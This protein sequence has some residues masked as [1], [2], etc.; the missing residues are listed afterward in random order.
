MI[1]AVILQI[2]LIALNA[3]FA[4]AEIAVISMGDTKLQMMAEEGNKKAVTL[5][6]LTKNP[7]KFLATIQVAITLSGFLG[8][9]YAAD[10][11]AEPLVE[12][13]VRFGI[14]IP[15]PVLDAV[16]VFAITLVISYFS[17]VFGELIPKR[18]AMQKK[19]GI[20]FALAGMLFVVSKIFAPLVWLLTASTNGVLKLLHIDPEQ[21]ERVTEE[22][23]RMMVEA[24]SEKGTIDMDENEMIQNVFE[25]NDI[26]AGAIC[27]HRKDVLV[28]EQEE[29]IEEWDEIIVGSRHRFYPVSGE[30]VDDII[31]VLD[32]KDYLR[33]KMHTKEEA[34]EKAIEEPF[35]VP[36]T[37]KADVLLQDMRKLGTYVAIVIDEYGGMEGIVTVKDLLEILVGDMRDN[38]GDG[39]VDIEKI[40]ENTWR[41]RGGALLKD[42]ADELEVELPE[43]DYDTFNGYICDLLGKVPVDG[44]HFSLDAGKLHIEVLSVDDHCAEETLVTKQE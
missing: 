4:S 44:S 29:S 23:I 35:F 33:M 12:V 25:M 42:V 6:K 38:D 2:V 37:M 15:E 36:E 14:G 1:G 18:V 9:A 10:N 24:G 17:I 30:D 40:S 19:E 39:T 20:A 11:F 26:T 31:G 5:L 43:K 16:C 32:S 28:L 3:V 7:A 13:L 8:S 21:D 41:I 22:E 34:F 27:T